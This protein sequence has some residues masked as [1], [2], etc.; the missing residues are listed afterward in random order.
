[1]DSCGSSRIKCIMR[2][3]VHITVT[4]YY[5]D[6]YICVYIILCIYAHIYGHI[7]SS[8]LHFVYKT[9]HEGSE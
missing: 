7:M 6:L 8:Q 5:A 3:R 1:M 2:V 4:M 9:L